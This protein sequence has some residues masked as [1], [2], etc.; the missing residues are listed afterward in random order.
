MARTARAILGGLLAAA[1]AAAAPVAVAAQELPEGVSAEMVRQGE[2]VYAGPGYCGTC[3]GSRGEG[4]MGVGSD[5]TDDRWLHLEGSYESIVRIVREGIP[6]ER[7][8]VGLPM[9]PRGGGSLTPGQVAA[10][11]AYVWTLSRRDGR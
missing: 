11:A 1:S 8:K 10:V 7:S 2:R 4:I 9:P 3:H 5:L 6:A